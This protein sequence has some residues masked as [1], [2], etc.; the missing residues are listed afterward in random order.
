MIGER[1]FKSL[2]TLSSTTM[3]ATIYFIKQNYV[4]CVLS[5]KPQII[6]YIIVLILPFILTI[7]SLLLGKFLQSETISTVKSVEE[8]SNNFLPSYLG[9]FFVGLSI[10]TDETFWYVFVIVF[11]FTYFSQSIYFN[12]ILLI[13]RYSF[14]YATTSKDK[15][16]LII[17]KSLLSTPDDL[18]K[19]KLKRINNFTFI[20][21]TE[22]D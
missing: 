9:Y 5:D 22:E 17:S 8:S 1:F 18:N 14:Y 4:F 13:L 6:S 20:K 7:I 15:K 19:V 12:P 16:I 3:L 2:L 21:T 10:N 11:I